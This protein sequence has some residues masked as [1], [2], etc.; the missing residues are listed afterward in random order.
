[1]D[2][3]E[4]GATTSHG[5]LR[6]RAVLAGPKISIISCSFDD[7]FD[8]SL[9]RVG[10]SKVVPQEYPNNLWNAA[11]TTVFFVVEDD[12]VWEG[13][14]GSLRL[15]NTGVAVDVILIVLATRR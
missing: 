9:L 3:A 4:T 5:R 1:M 7:G 14:V 12:G 15:P 2:G 8:E 6:I 13:S 10:R 11:S